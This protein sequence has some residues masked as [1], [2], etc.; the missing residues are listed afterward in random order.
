MSATKFHTRHDTTHYLGDQIRGE[1]GAACN[2]IEEETVDDTGN[3]LCMGGSEGKTLFGKHGLQMEL[4]YFGSPGR[5]ISVV[6][7]NTYYELSSFSSNLISGRKRIGRLK[8]CC[9]EQL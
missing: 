8:K 1:M 2:T 3:W 9:R 7:P 4:Q 6:H 5:V